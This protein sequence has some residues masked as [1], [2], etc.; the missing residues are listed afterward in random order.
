MTDRFK[1]KDSD[2]VVEYLGTGVFYDIEEIES[3]YE[4]IRHRETC[5]KYRETKTGTEVLMPIL[6]FLNYFE[7]YDKPI[8]DIISVLDNILNAED[9]RHQ[10]DF[11][12]LHSR[13][14]ETNEERPTEGVQK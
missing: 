3:C 2:L 6:T 12:T 13:E 7:P 4:P 1:N 9:E 8:T 11:C 10:K 5:I 14:S